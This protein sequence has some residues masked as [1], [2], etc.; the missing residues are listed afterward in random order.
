MGFWVLDFGGLLWARVMCWK[1]ERD[2]EVDRERSEMGYSRDGRE[3]SALAEGI[4][5]EREREE[6]EMKKEEGSGF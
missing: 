2:D 5:G 3:F 4:R 1:R 6:D